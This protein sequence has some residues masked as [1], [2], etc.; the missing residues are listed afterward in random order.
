MSLNNR[1]HK[2]AVALAAALGAILLL[3]AI[4]AVALPAFAPITNWTPDTALIQERASV[5]VVA[6]A[7]SWIYVVGGRDATGK[8]VDDVLRAN[9]RTDGSLGAW[10][11][12]GPL[13]VR[14][15]LHTVV[16]SGSHVY[17]LGGYDDV[18]YRREVWRSQMTSDGALT[19]WQRDRDLP[20]AVTLHAATEANNRIYVSGGDTPQGRTN[21][22]YVASI[23]ENGALADWQE[24]AALPPASLYRHAMTAMSD[25]LLVTGGYDG[26]TVRAESYSARI[27]PDGTLESWQMSNLPGPREYHQSVIHDGRLVLIGGRD[28][29]SSLG[30]TRVDSALTNALGDWASEPPL[31]EPLYRFGAITIRK[32]GSDYIYVIGGLSGNSY[33][34]NVYHSAVPPA[35]PSATPTATSSPT[36]TATPTGVWAAWREP[37]R[38]ILLPPQGKVDIVLEYYKAPSSTDLS[39]GVTGAAVFQQNGQPLFMA[40]VPPGSGSYTL[41]LKPKAGALPGAQFSLS[42]QVG[43][44]TLKPDPREGLIARAMAYLPVIVNGWAPPTPTPT[45]T[46]TRTPTLTAT[47]TITPTVTLTP[48]TT[49]TITPSVTP[50]VISTPVT[51]PP[52]ST[53]CV[54]VLIKV[55]PGEAAGTAQIY[56][57]VLPN[58]GDKKYLSSRP[59]KIAATFKAGYRFEKWTQDADGSIPKPKFDDTE[60]TPGVQDVTVT[61]EFTSTA[62]GDGSWL[63]SL[64]DILDSWR[65]DAP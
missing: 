31:P 40:K 30:L 14:L 27:K 37:V 43:N 51:P 20:S 52:A 50:S 10:E 59:I 47:P 36:A 6:Q 58:C 35:T 16:A 29:T 8:A 4:S 46:P 19:S 1:R 49:S 28:S 26:S 65:L 2:A 18:N 61:A 23:G 56:D 60:F 63:A 32:N 62:S 45:R 5:G 41:T 38:L 9:I 48:S 15:Y 33:R 21:K 64:F 17:V 12:L 13:P 53:S 22:V 11:S 54:S 34:G 3:G 44:F 39:A 55:M 57:P 24:V 42:A 25:T 7:D